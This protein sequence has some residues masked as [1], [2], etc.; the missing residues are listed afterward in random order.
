ML[1][2]KWSVFHDV[3]TLTLMVTLTVEIYEDDEE[4]PTADSKVSP[5]KEY[6]FEFYYE[7]LLKLWPHYFP[8]Y[9]KGIV[10]GKKI[11]IICKCY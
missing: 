10:S 7:L 5:S 8:V 11:P 2:K 1:S 9:F 6:I 3:Y 4:Q